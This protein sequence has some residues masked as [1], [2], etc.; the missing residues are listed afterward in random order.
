VL[1]VQLGELAVWLATAPVQC[2]RHPA[3]IISENT[4]LL[5]VHLNLSV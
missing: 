5:G 1:L 3:I 4:S 2:W